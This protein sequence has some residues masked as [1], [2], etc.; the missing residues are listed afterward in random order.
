MDAETLKSIALLA[1][2]M[3]FGLLC[4]AFG[5]TRN[6]KQRRQAYNEGMAAGYE[7]GKTLGHR[8]AYKIAENL[9]NCAYKEGYLVGIGTAYSESEEK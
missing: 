7:I 9:P 6:S 3:I 8:K 1:V 5:T 2:A 4:I